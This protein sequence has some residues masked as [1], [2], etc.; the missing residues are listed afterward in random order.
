[1][2]GDSRIVVVAREQSAGRGRA[3]RKWESGRN[4]G[5]FATFVLPCSRGVDEVS[6]FPLAVGVAALRVFQRFGV[7]AGLKWPNDIWV[8]GQEGEPEGKLCGILVERTAGTNAPVTAGVGVNLTQPAMADDFPAAALCVAAKRDLDYGEVLAE[9]AAEVFS[10]GDEFDRS[11]LAPFL[12][13][14]R[15]CS[16]LSGKRVSIVSGNEEYAADV[17]GIAPNG[18]LLIQRDGMQV[19]LYS[20]DVHVTSWRR[21]GLWA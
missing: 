10:C 7:H 19:E 5:I 3:G 9:L 11:G 4:R 17:L 2:G 1:M 15:D 14:C 13:E 12:A 8:L 16:I 6:G 18:A 21:G 20:G